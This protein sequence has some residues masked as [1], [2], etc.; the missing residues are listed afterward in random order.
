MEFEA[1]LVGVDHTFAV[2]AAWAREESDQVI[3]QITLSRSHPQ[4]EV[5]PGI[6]GVCTELGQQEYLTY[7][8][9]TQ[10]VLS[11]TCLQLIFSPE[12]AAELGGVSTVIVRFPPGHETELTK[13]LDFI[14]SDCSCYS[15]GR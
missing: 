12:A 6:E 14:F 8:G 5:I 9:I 2:V 1:N 11:D 15:L 7:G 4:D 13:A 3:Y 10:A